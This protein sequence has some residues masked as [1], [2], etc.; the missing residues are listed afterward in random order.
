MSVQ[1]NDNN[2]K[3]NADNAATRVASPC[4]HIC[5]LDEQDVCLGCHRTGDEICGWGAMTNDE[6][7]AVLVKV[8]ER[9]RADKNFMQF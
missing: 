7:K 5:C 2:Q 9:E 8:A 6:R 3:P 1:N 4:V